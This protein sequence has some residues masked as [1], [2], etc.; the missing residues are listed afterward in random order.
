MEPLDHQDNS[1]LFLVLLITIK[2]KKISL[3]L[4]KNNLTF[5]FLLLVSS[6]CLN[7]FQKVDLKEL[8]EYD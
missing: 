4:E 7:Y 8:L 2:K 6:E 5:V 3:F 1:S